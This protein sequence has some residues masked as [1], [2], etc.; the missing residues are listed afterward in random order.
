MYGATGTPLVCQGHTGCIYKKLSLLFNKRQSR[1]ELATLAVLLNE[2]WHR[3]RISIH[4][5]SK[6]FTGDTF[7]ISDA[8]FCGRSLQM[9]HQNQQMCGH[10]NVLAVVGME[11]HGACHLE[12]CFYFTFSTKING[13]SIYVQREQCTQNP[14]TFYCIICY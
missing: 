11:I 3:P 14:L 6:V 9:P 4:T 12:N 10:F 7:Q 1:P 5:K 8:I 13:D 2:N